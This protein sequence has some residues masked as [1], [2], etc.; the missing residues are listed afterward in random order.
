MSDI[1]SI[2]CVFGYNLKRIRND[3]GITQKSLAEKAGT[4]GTYIA[5]IEKCAKFP[6]AAMIGRI[7]A[8]L[9]IAPTDLFAPIEQTFETPW[10]WAEKKK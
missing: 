5:C 3:R 4:V 7:S 10:N 1:P 2:Q 6:S 9:E 8:A